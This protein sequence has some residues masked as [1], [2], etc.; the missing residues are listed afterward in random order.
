MLRQ[1]QVAQREKLQDGNHGNGVQPG[2]TEK[3]RWNQGLNLLLPLTKSKKDNEVQRLSACTCK[4]LGRC[5][6][7]VLLT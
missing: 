5:H 1:E 6:N 3:R 4:H 7:Q 2:E